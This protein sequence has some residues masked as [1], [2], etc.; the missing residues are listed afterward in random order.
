[1]SILLAL[2]KI[3]EKVIADQMYSAFSV[4]LLPNLS[5][6]LKGHSCC[7]ALL[8]MVEDWRL[9]HDNR[10]A[11]ATIAVDLSK[12]FDSVCHAL[13]LAKLRA[14]CFT[15]QVLEFMENYPRDRRQRFKIDGVYSRWKT[16]KVGVPQGFLLGLWFF[17]I[18]INDLNFLVTNTS[19]RLYAEDATE[20]A[21]D[22]SPPLLEYIINSDL[23]LLSTWFRQNYLE[24]NV[25]K[26]QVMAI[27]PVSYCYDFSVDNN[28]VVTTD[29]LNI[30]GAMLD[31]KLNFV[32]YVKEQ[33]KKAC[34]KASALRRIRRFIPS[35]IMGCLCKA[36]I[37]P[38]LE[39][40]HLPHL[41]FAIVWG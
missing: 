8:K 9:S 15:D 26:T 22:V 29:T 12:A 1:V 7:T 13:Q 3:Y 37:F 6:Y 25:F 32:A 16:V 36:Y 40:N 27:G 21:S 31:C 19:L 34:A 11:V 38:H 28:A 5:G 30:L 35:D 41:L 14:Y 2:S 10:E 23:H 20:Y 39:V 24:L 4:S 17:N 18:Y 33:V